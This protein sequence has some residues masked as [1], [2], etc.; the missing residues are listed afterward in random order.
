ARIFFGSSILSVA[1]A[2][3][4]LL[5]TIFV[6]RWFGAATY[7]HFIVD[8]AMIGLLLIVLEVVPSNYSV[9]RIQDDPAWQRSIAVQITVTVLIGSAVVFAAGH[10]G[11]VFQAY[12]LW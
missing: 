6:V 1:S 7:S 3:L 2:G 9:F 12:S 5:T 8:L 11:V 10:W 4:N